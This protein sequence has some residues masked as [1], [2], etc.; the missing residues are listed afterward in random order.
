MKQEE[1]DYVI[2]GAGSAGCVLAARLTE[3]PAITV[4]LLEAGGPD[5]SVLIHAP[6]GVVAMVPTKINNYGYETVPQAALNGRRGYQPRGKTLGGSSSIN[7]MLYV[8]GNRWDYDHWASLGNPGWSYADVLPLFRRAE[9]NEQFVDEFHGQGG[10]LNVTYPQFDSAMSQT[11]LQAAA[12]QGIPHNPDY[13]GAIQDGAF[14]YQA[15]HRNGE[16]CSA[17]KAYLTPNLARPNL[18]VLTHAV[19]E[20]VH[21]EQGRATGVSYFQG[22][23]LKNVRA[24]REVIL[25][26][27]TFGSPQMLQLSGIGAGATLQKLGI[28]VIHDLPGVGQNLQDHIDY[29]Q[30]WRVPSDTET[31]G[32]SARC[33]AR[34]AGA[35]LEWKSRRTGMMTTTYGTAGAF[36]RSSPDVPAPDLQMIFVVAIV[37]DHARKLHMGHGIS[38]HV[39]VLRPHSTGT[40]TLN[41]TD[42]RDAPRI[43]PQFLSDERDVQLLLHGAQMQQRIIESGAFD[44]VRGKMLHPVRSNDLAALEQDIRNRADTQ[45]H[46]V[47]TCKMGPESDPMAVVDARLRVRGIDGL[48]VVDASIMPAQVSGNTNAPTIMI[49]EKAADLIR[50]DARNVAGGHRDRA[51]DISYVTQYGLMRS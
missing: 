10:P 36:I 16:R 30:T 42:P 13:N 27:G 40:V 5:K 24:R 7:A 51:R 46:P 15:T 28:P 17:A 34:I 38:C 43:D 35:M 1:F 37:D 41:S 25:A 45:Y 6:A 33:A 20:R 47:G 23:Q 49:G 2:V 31:I 3:D 18:K 19:S 29:V 11:F 9:H 4:C 22:N 48:R 12:A 50:E 44:T 8:R 14:I 39:D 32:L 21:V 26:A